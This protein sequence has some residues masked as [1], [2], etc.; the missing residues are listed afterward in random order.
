MC[1]ANICRVLEEWAEEK[2]QGK[3]ERERLL[4]E[5]QKERTRRDQDEQTERR[6]QAPFSLSQY[7][8][9]YEY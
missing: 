5:Q 1:H 3:R 2:R 6:G 9:L 8:N 4:E 7:P